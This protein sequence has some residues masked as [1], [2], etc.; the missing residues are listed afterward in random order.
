MTEEQTPGIGEPADREAAASDA[1]PFA[2]RP[3][4]FVGAAFVGGFALAQ[5][6]KRISK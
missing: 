1:D 3:E 4:L 6:L 2:E 5:I